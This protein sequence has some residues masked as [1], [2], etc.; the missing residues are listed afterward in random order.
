LRSGRLEYKDAIVTAVPTTA[1]SPVE[2]PLPRSP[3]EKS[4]LNDAET[5]PGNGVD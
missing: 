1:P 2:V 3:F 5:N 4:H